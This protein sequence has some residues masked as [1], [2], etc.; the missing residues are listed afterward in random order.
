MRVERFD[1]GWFVTPDGSD[2]EPNGSLTVPHDAMLHEARRAER[3]RRSPL[4]H[5]CSTRPAVSGRHLETSEAVLAD[6]P[7]TV[8]HGDLF[9]AVTARSAAL[10]RAAEAAR[11]R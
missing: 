10:A 6:E 4:R 2:G 8:T 7:Y 5:R 9:D 3:P 11:D 1:E